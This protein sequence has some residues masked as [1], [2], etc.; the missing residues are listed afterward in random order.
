MK[1]RFRQY[2][3][4]CEV[5]PPSAGNGNG[6]GAGTA[7][8]DQQHQQLASKAQ[9]EL[10][11]AQTVLDNPATAPAERKKT[12]ANLQATNRQVQAAATDSTVSDLSKQLQ[13]LLPTGQASTVTAMKKKQKKR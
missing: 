6:G 7:A 12:L 3:Q 10:K 8:A 11:Q 1:G 9:G 2:V 4:L 5:A 13:N